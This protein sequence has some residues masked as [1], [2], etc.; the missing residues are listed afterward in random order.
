MIVFGYNDVIAS[1][2]F[3][4]LHEHFA[5]AADSWLLGGSGVSAIAGK[6]IGSHP[7]LG[8]WADD[9][10]LTF[11]P[12]IGAVLIFLALRAGRKRAIEFVEA[13]LVQ[14]Y[15]ALVIFC[16]LPIQGPFYSAPLQSA[17]LERAVQAAMLE[18]ANHAF[19]HTKAI[20]GFDYYIGFPSLHVG[21]VMVAWW[22]LREWRIPKILSSLYLVLVVPCVLLVGWHYV[23]DVIGGVA[24][25]AAAIALARFA[26]NFRR[27]NSHLLM[28]KGIEAIG[29]SANAAPRSEELV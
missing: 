13:L 10:Y 1:V 14:Y 20:I 19:Q 3:Y 9:F 28:K 18:Q 27:V 4:A 29:R 17:G 25:A 24:V 21:M 8:V 6:I 15:L 7:A 11:Y 16:F 26:S 23:V 12:A 2:R 22:F 5:A